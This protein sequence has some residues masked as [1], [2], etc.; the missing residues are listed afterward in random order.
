MAVMDLQSKLKVLDK[1]SEGQNKKSKKVVC[2]RLAKE[3]EMIQKLKIET[4]RT[5]SQNVNAAIGGGIPKG[6]MTLIAGLPDSGK[7]FFLLETIALNMKKDPNFIAAWLESEHSL[8]EQ[9]ILEQF[10]IDPERFYLIDHNKDDAAEGALDIVESIANSGSVDF[11]VINSL[12]SLVPSKIF[13]DTM[14]DQNIGLQARLNSK[15]M[16]KII[17]A[18]AS[19]NMALAVITHLS[20][21]IGSMSRDPLIVAGGKSIAF[22]ASITLDFRKRS[23]NDSDPIGKEDGIKVGVTVKK[24]HCITNIYPYVKTEYYAIFGQGVERYLEILDNAV[25]QG[26]LKKAGAWIND[27][28]ESTGEARVFDN[29]EVAKWQGAQ[30]F[31]EYLIANPEYFEYLE[32]MVSGTYESLS[33]SE[34]KEVQ[35][36]NATLEEM[37]KEDIDPIAD[38]KKKSKKKKTEENTTE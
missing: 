35:S 29:G 18:I 23:M 11:L 33:E 28:D 24:N 26:I 3:S 7:T 10:E 2:G 19:S 17:P 14:A 5:P 15:F 1:I 8:N 34:I 30:K 21:D 31:R 13:R 32:A 4:F 37:S 16:Q 20:T 9:A 27:I 36:D 6:R 25:N 22:A 38:N 12:K